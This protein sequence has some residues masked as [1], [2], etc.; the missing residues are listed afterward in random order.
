MMFRVLT[1]QLKTLE[2]ELIIYEVINKE[3]VDEDLFEGAY[4]YAQISIE[5]SNRFLDEFHIAREFISKFP[6]AND[7]IYGENIRLHLL[8]KFPYHIHYVI[9][10]ERKQVIV[11]AVIFGKKG[12][13]DF[14]RRK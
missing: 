2:S 6:Y 9:D 12:N 8:L 10:E 13:I 7:V 11:L 14:S 4:Y 5:L 3:L 1:K